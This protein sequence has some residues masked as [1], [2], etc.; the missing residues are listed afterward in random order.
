MRC[1]ELVL[2][3]AETSWNHFVFAV[4]LTRSAS[5]G[6]FI[7]G[8]LALYLP[9]GRVLDSAVHWPDLGVVCRLLGS[10]PLGCN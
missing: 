6:Y 9:S 2:S 1:D 5:N 10:P 8:F 7:L 4:E 3:Q